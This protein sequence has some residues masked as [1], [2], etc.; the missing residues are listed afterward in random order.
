MVIPHYKEVAN[1]LDKTSQIEIDIVLTAFFKEYGLEELIPSFIEAFVL[2][3]GV[4]LI[5][6]LVH[7]FRRLLPPY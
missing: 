4:F 2:R 6:V 3:N 1:A 5:T 7:G